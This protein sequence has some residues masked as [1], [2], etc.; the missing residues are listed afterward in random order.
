MMLY[1]CPDRTALRFQG[2]GI[3]YVDD[4]SISRLNRKVDSLTIEMVVRP[5]RN[6]RQGFGPLLLLHDGDDGRQMAIWQYKDSLIVMN[7]NDYNNARRWPRITGMHVLPPDQIRYLT[8][9]ASKKKGSRLFVN[10]KPVAAKKRLVFADSFRRPT[11]C[12]WYW[13]ILFMAIMAG[14]AIYTGWE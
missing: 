4:L 9:T 14:S 1:G 6:Q 7:G 5:G 2:S 10:G 11:R 3:A 8:I 13:V 12:V